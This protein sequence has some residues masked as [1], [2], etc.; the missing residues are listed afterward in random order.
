M[1][2]ST[3]IQINYL[4]YRLKGILLKTVLSHSN[5]FWSDF[6][7]Y[8]SPHLASKCAWTFFFSVNNKLAVG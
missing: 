7:P 1:F 6:C 2:K 4:N 3:R 5:G 8:G